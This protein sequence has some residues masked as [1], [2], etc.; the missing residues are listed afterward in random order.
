MK[1][2]ATTGPLAS[3]VDAPFSGAT[4]IARILPRWMPTLRTLSGPDSGSITRPLAMTTS[5]DS[6]ADASRIEA[7]VEATSAEASIAVF[8]V[9]VTCMQDLQAPAFLGG[10]RASGA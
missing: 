6:S 1:P 5:Y 3:I 9:A 10:T 7:T 4:E 8:S 2:A